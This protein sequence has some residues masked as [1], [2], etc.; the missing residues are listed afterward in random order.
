LKLDSVTF[1]SLVQDPGLFRAP[2]PLF[3]LT[4][5]EL[6]TP[7]AIVQLVAACYALFENGKSPTVVIPDQGVRS[8]LMRAG[9]D[10]ALEGV[11]S[12]QPSSF[13][14]SYRRRRRS[15]PMLIEVTKIGG[16]SDLPDVLDQI[17]D[18]LI[19]TLGY[20]QYDAFDVGTAVSEVSQNIFD[21]NAD[22]KSYGFLA[23]QVYGTGTR[24]FLEIGIA[25]CGAGLTTSL[26]RNP[27]NGSIQTDSQAILKA[28]ELGTSEYD[29]PTRGSGL[30]HLL[31]LAYRNAG[32]VQIRSGAAKVRYR[33]DKRQGWA[34][35]VG[36]LPGV[37]VALI[38]G[39]RS[40]L[41][42]RNLGAV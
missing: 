8:Y 13:S 34:F 20:E 4:R 10:T 27:N 3:D 32:C 16:C 15:N 25:D 21:H 42:R 33:G 22:R 35:D 38:L 5:V 7:A 39:S 31:Q 14:N 26:S 24:R 9:F 40:Q 11:A 41:S 2:N 19:G 17:V 36:H 37:Q 1:D 28:V 23:M 30:F 6:I 18:V 12:V 29:D